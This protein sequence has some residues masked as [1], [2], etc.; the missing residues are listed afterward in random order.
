M[1]SRTLRRVD[2]P[3][4]RDRQIAGDLQ[5]RAEVGFDKRKAVVTFDDARTS[6]WDLTRATADAGYPSE[7][8][9]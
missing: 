9:R 2:Q 6:L 3:L 7:L 1:G 8:R 5:P 4:D